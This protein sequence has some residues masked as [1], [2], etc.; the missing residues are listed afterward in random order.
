MQRGPADLGAVEPDVAQGPVVQVGK[1]ANS[2]A[3]KKPVNSN[4]TGDA[5]SGVSINTIAS[6]KSAPRTQPIG[7]NSSPAKPSD[8][9]RASRSR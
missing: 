6:A 9:F 7:V 8:L 2:D 1:L 5:R 3:S 4:A